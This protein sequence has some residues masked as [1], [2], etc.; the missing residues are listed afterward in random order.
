MP[1]TGLLV[2]LPLQ[3]L[4][5]QLLPGPVLPLSELVSLTLRGLGSGSGIEMGAAISG[6]IR[7]MDRGEEI[8]RT[9]DR[10][11]RCSES[12]YLSPSHSPRTTE[13]GDAH[14]SLFTELLSDHNQSG[15]VVIHER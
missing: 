12:W 8:T 1:S 9:D 3:L 5:P 15:I 2:P 4:A 6:D 7:D 14:S 11:D 13:P 10:I